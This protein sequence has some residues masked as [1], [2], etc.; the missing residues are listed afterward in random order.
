MTT[1]DSSQPLLDGPRRDSTGH[2]RPSA[3]G[4]RSVR[5]ANFGVES[6]GLPIVVYMAAALLASSV[7]Q[8]TGALPTPGRAAGA[9]SDAR[10]G[11]AARGAES[12]GG[13]DSAEG[14]GADSSAST[15]AD[16]TSGAAGATS[17][18][19]MVIALACNNLAQLAGAAACVWVAMRQ[20]R[21]RFAELLLCGRSLIQ[22]APMIFGLFVAAMVVCYGTLWLILKILQRVSPTYQAHGHDVVELIRGGGLPFWAIAVLW[23]GAVAVAPWAEELFFRGVIQTWLMRATGRRLVAVGVTAAIFGAVHLSWSPPQ[24]HAVLPLGLLAVLLGLSY[25]RTDA[26]AVPITVHALFNLSTMIAVTQGWS[27]G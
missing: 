21:R 23:I 11:P 27:D 9:P 24:F 22:F 26:L 1:P 3:G 5:D 4:W 2:D 15:A 25:E 16:T 14:G 20:R 10:N 18:S 8:W 13:A 6:I 17:P 7:L 12:A 19:Q